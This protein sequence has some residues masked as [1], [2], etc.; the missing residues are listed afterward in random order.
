MACKTVFSLFHINSVIS[1]FIHTNPL[2]SI[3]P[4]VSKVKWIVVFMPFSHIK[5]IKNEKLLDFFYIYGIICTDL[6]K[7]KLKRVVATLFDFCNT[8]KDVSIW[9]P[10]GERT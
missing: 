6:N 2:K 4:K 8:K 1:I 7:L 10:K 5:K 3:T 9:Q